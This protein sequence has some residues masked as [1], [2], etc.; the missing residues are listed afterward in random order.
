MHTV[1]LSATPSPLPPQN[2]TGL[3]RVFFPLIKA[4]F[5]G[6]APG[7]P[8]PLGAHPVLSGRLLRRCYPEFWLC[9][10]CTLEGNS[11]LGQFIIDS[12]VILKVEIL[13]EPSQCYPCLPQ[14]A[15][16]KIKSNLVSLLSVAF[17]FICRQP[18]LSSPPLLP[19]IFFLFN[20]NI[21][22]PR[23]LLGSLEF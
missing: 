14:E 7:C 1:S 6:G 23:S 21:R 18:L 13:H 12:P 15:L 17:F 8:A 5:T 9:C 16:I 20:L 2:E 22:L 11:R 19:Y 10:C 4:D 3:S